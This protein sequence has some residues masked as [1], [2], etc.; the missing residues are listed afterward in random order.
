MDRQKLSVSHQKPSRRS[1][2]IYAIAAA[3]IIIVVPVAVGGVLIARFNPNA[4]APQIVEAV[5]KATGRTLTIGGQIHL[6]LSLRPTLV[7]SDLT[8][9]NPTGYTD[10]YLLTLT[11]VQ[12]QIALLPLLHHR[13][14]ILQLKLVAP[15]LY[16]ERNESGQADWNLG[17]PAAAQP[18]QTDAT[19]PNA[20]TSTT[21]KVALESV[22]L[23]DGQIIFRSSDKN[24][25]TTISLASFT[26]Q[27]DSLSAPLHV[28]GLAD[29]GSTA[30]TLQG[31]VGAVSDL[32]SRTATPWPLDLQLGFAGAVATVQG[33]VIRPETLGRY[34]LHFTAQAPALEAVGAALPPAWLHNKNLPALHD[35]SISGT[36]VGQANA[37]PTLSNI[38]LTAGASDLSNLWPGLHLTTLSASLPTLT[39]T[40]TL[41]LKGDIAQLPLQAQA[42]WTDLASFL[43]PSALPDGAPSPSFTSTL[44]VTLGN[45]TAS[46]N[47]GFATPRSLSGA[48]WAVALNIPD[49]SALSPA[50]GAPLPAFKAITLQT[51]LTDS[52]GQG[53]LRGI[54]LN[55]ISANM[56]NL[57]LG[58]QASLTPGARPDLTLQLAIADG[59]LDAL[60]A[61]MPTASNDSTKQNPQTNQAAPFSSLPLSLLRRADADITIRADHLVYDQTNYDALETHAVLKNGRLT[62][63]PF[64]VQLPGGAVFASGNIDANEEPAAEA[65]KVS[66][67][68]LAL[69]PLMQML[70]LP[71][72]A[73]GTAQIQMNI[74]THG[75]TPA[76]ML[77]AVSGQFGLASVNGEI[78]GGAIDQI[79]GKALKAVNL[80]SSLVGAAGSVPVRC[81]ALRL[82]AKDGS[83]TIRAL[84]FDSSRL[85]IVG[86]GT[87]N[88][89]S[90]TLDL[91]LKPHLRVSST[92]VV[93]PISVGGTFSSP[94][95]SV[96]PDTAILAAGQVAL[97]LKET[98]LQ[99]LLGNNSIL[100]KITN[101]LT[102]KKDENDVCGPAL[103]LARM[104]QPG[105][106]P[107]PLTDETSIQKQQPLSGPRS[108]LNT[109]LTQ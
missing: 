32:T 71:S 74:T 99:K 77:G 103:Q 28:S 75:D 79:L 9:S 104:G 5:G 76:A 52:G 60:R 22:S 87:V 36:L 86:G 12:A 38:A 48:A 49:L 16:L 57:Q 106:S 88:F 85:L 40:N 55:T 27:A 83:G 17:H 105:P 80:P 6:Q 62:V 97:G 45:A 100:G 46:L 90:Q 78:D 63:A 31:V 101:A 43:P 34:D 109:L 73:Q 68:A 94:Q 93:V 65:L 18:G 92:N 15:K 54:A 35:V 70:N 53:L 66:A 64:T 56:E 51:T 58:G 98:P 91:V 37:R 30:L 84:T 108:L 81:A 11:Q 95:Y 10:P 2:R 72:A 41:S 29:I 82:D 1:L 102:G 61:A 24:Q 4:Y 20:A 107:R 44:S 42:Q 47:G 3:G 39:G 13:L 89:A 8:L 96:A 69:A 67:P 21:Y 50:W 23:E 25:P 7:A 26:G 19:P 33:Q 14:D 59:N